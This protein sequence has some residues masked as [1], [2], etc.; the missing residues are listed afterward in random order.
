MRMNH[1]EGYALTLDDESGD[2]RFR[3]SYRPYHYVTGTLRGSPHHL[4]RVKTALQNAEW[5]V[6]VAELVYK[7]DEW[8]LHV[9]V[10]HT[11]HTVGTPD[12][13]AT[14]VGVDIN[15]D[16]IALA[17]MTRAD[18][19]Q[20]SIVIEYPDIKRVRHEFFTKRKRMQAA[21]QAAFENVVQSEERD[22][23]HD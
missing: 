13:A 22:F 21:G 14:I 8:R 7:H 20:D 11:Q 15:E 19:V 2:V 6:G 9:T 17:A 12:D 5:R 10:T 1:E 23:V 18:G 3:V 4:E 16:C